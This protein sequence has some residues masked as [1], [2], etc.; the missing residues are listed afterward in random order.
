MSLDN[1]ITG[2]TAAQTVPEPLF[3][4]ASYID[5]SIEGIGGAILATIA[6]LFP[7]FLLLFGIL[8]FWDNIKSNIYAEGFL[9]GI[10]ADVVGIIIAAFIT[11][12]GLQRL[13]Q[14]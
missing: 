8:P 4:F 3:T 7:V 14:N 5:K 2:Y 1:F 11:R 9:K 6:I 10:S 12:F 13:H